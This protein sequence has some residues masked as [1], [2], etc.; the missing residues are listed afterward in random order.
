MTADVPEQA[1]FFTITQRLLLDARNHRDLGKLY[2][3]NLKI[4]HAKF[5]LLPQDAQDGLLELQGQ[6]ALVTGWSRP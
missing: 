4:G 5:K 3:A 2:R 1:K 6:A